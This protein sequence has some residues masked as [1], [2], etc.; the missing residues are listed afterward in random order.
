L[1]RSSQQQKKPVFVKPNLKS[2]NFLSE[3]SKGVSSKKE[4]ATV[5]ETAVLESVVEP[6]VDPAAD[7]AVEPVNEPENSEVRKLQIG[8]KR[9][10]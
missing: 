7:P 6:V 5:L 1:A 2:N 10:E 3:K 9:K 4:Q 8:Y